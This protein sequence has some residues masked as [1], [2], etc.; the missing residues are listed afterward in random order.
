MKFAVTFAIALVGFSSIYV[1]EGRGHGG[2]GGHGRGGGHG[3][4]GG[5]GGR[6]GGSHSVSSGGSHSGS[7]GSNSGSSGG[8]HSSSDG[9]GGYGGSH[10]SGSYGGSHSSGSYGGSHSSGSYGGSHSDSYGGS[11][12]DG[13]GGSHSD[14]HYSD[15]FSSGTHS[16]THGGRH[17]D[18]WDDYK[19]GGYDYS[20][21]KTSYDPYRDSLPSFDMSMTGFGTRKRPEPRNEFDELK[22]MFPGIKLPD[23][24]NLGYKPGVGFQLPGIDDSGY[25][26]HRSSMFGFESKPSHSEKPTNQKT[27]T[28]PKPSAPASSSTGNGDASHTN[29]DSQSSVAM[30]NGHRHHHRHGH[31]HGH[32]SNS[33]TPRPDNT[34]TPSSASPLPIGFQTTMT[35]EAGQAPM[36]PHPTVHLE[37]PPTTPPHHSL[38][39]GVPQVYHSL[40]QPPGMIHNPYHIPSQPGMPIYGQP[41]FYGRATMAQPIVPGQVIVLPSQSNPSPGLG[42]IAAEAFVHSAINAGVNR[43]INGPSHQHTV[44]RDRKQQ[45][46]GS[47]TITNSTTIIYNNYGQPQGTTTSEDRTHSSGINVG[48]RSSVS[49]ASQNTGSNSQLPAVQYYIPDDELMKISEALF[50]KEETDLN[51]HVIL[52]L[53]SKVKAE[54]IGDEAPRVLLYSN[55]DLYDMPTIRVLQNLFDNYQL[56]ATTKENITDE[57]RKEQHLLLDTFFNTDIMTTAMDWLARK[58]YV[59]PDDFEMKDTLRR[60]WFNKIEGSTSGFERVFLAEIYPGSTVLGAQNWIY[61]MSKEASRD[62]DYMGY[63]EEHPITDKARLLKLNLKIGDAVKQ[64]STML[65]GTSPELEMALYTICFYARPNDICPVSLGGH[66]FYLYTHTFRYF[67]KDLI[68][69]GIIAF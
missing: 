57:M 13:Y 34:T 26:S 27:N 38:P 41:P 67:G 5:H 32:G 21:S 60:T 43:A 53:Q 59:E 10:S 56:N 39:S 33:T 61:F 37:T 16:G 55:P 64:N 44:S 35:P 58:N 49:N 15:T 63:S 54:K 51:K 19:Y 46:E 45:P 20:N 40:G 29:Q 9:G 28:D 1:A 17:S 69:I 14:D 23:F 30:S 42:Q 68:D 8:V 12:S 22:E 50:A 18:N 65:V 11:H 47:S 66:K 48:S 31:R 62:I 25:H 4:G 24:D 2:R 6:G 36:Q 3:H 7:G 52:N